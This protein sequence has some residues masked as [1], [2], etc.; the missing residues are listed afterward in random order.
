VTD[1]PKQLRQLLELR[2]LVDDGVEGALQS[3]RSLA[4]AMAQVLPLVAR[5]LD[6]RAAFVRTFSEDLQLTT[7]MHPKHADVQQLGAVIDIAKPGV[8]P[9]VL[10]GE[11]TMIVAQPL[12]VGGEWFGSAGLVFG[13]DRRFDREFLLEGLHIFCEETDNFFFSVRAARE[14]HLLMMDLGEALRDRVLPEG[15]R[16][17]VAVLADAMPLDRLLL[18][19]IGEDR[20]SRLQAQ[21]FQGATLVVDTMGTLPAA[22]EHPEIRE[23]AR[24]YLDRRD[25]RLMKRFGFVGAREEVLINGITQAVV[26]GKILA[27]SKQGSFNTYDRELLSAFGEFIRQRIVDFDKE[28]RSLAC[29]F[30][31]DDVARLLQSEDYPRR[32][33]SPREK[34]VAILYSDISGF[35]RLSEQVLKTPS[36]VADLVEAWSREAVDL[37]W[38][39]G[40]VFDKMVGDCVIAL[41]GPPFYD[42]SPEESVTAAIRCARAI[43]DMTA[44]FPERNGFEHLRDSGLAVSSGVNLAPLFVGRFGPNSAFTGFSSGMNNTARLQCLADRGEILVMNS[45]ISRLPGTHPFTFGEERS[46]KVKNVAEPLVFRSLIAE[47][48]QPAL[49]AANAQMDEAAIHEIIL[50]APRGFRPSDW[51]ERLM[52][53]DES[54]ELGADFVYVKYVKGQKVLAVRAELLDP[55]HPNKRARIGVFSQVMAFA[56]ENGHR[57]LVDPRLERTSPALLLALRRFC[58]ERG[59][60]LETSG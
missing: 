11:D 53:F 20:T 1:D 26:V 42:R 48:E 3:R 38:R 2:D 45:A 6:A 27:T 12:D 31:E 30:R 4:D 22:P 18:V 46:A 59:M 5:A 35:T 49:S 10:D 47:V 8:Q 50:M 13:A 60:K 14:K 29:S 34:E 58:D 43:R 55:E 7:F 28:W 25:P 23:E 40:G 33:L 44:H 16:R 21:L 37:V 57:I 19:C 9:F 56:R 32:Y 39:H 36:A 52:N 54:A 51:A 41:F 17:A 24:A 15:V